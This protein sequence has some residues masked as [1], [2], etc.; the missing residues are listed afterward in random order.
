MKLKATL[1]A[2][3][4]TL[5]LAP[6]AHAYQGL[7]GAIGAGLSYI[8]PDRDVEALT[9]PVIFDTNADFDNGIGVYTALG[10]ARDSGWRTELEYN[11][12][13][14]DVRHWTGD[15]LGYAGFS[16]GTLSGDIT[17]HAVMANLIKDLGNGDNGITPY[18]G[19]GIGYSWLDLNLV[20]TNPTAVGGFGNLIVNDTAGALAYQGIA[21]LAIGLAE[22]LALDLSY[23]YFALAGKPDFAGTLNG[24]AMTFDH[25]YNNHS[26]YAGLRWNFGGSAPAVQ[27]KDCWD[28]SSVPVSAECPP[29]LVEDASATPDDFG[30]IVYFDYDKANLTPEAAALVKEAADRALADDIETV[31]V[32]GNTDRSGSSAYNQ[33]LSTRRANVVRDALVAN[34]V[35]AD[36]IETSAFGEDNNAKPTPD[37]VREPLNRRTEVTISFE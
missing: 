29:Q 13:S 36:R 2:A 25:A 17:S 21:G 23:R 10:I 34:G 15:G 16:G 35:P 7:Y 14:N 19:A 28:G 31:R 9:G 30:I 26:L 11:Y 12:R 37:G 24:A 6:A 1:F 20:G 32:E 27:Y 18:I 33:Q 8:G 4:A 22:G 5:A 3:T